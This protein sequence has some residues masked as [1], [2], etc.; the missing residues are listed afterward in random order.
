MRFVTELPQ[1]ILVESG[2]LFDDVRVKEVD[3]R[4]H[5]DFVIARVLERGTLCSVRALVRAVDEERIRTFFR[6]G[7]AFQVSRRTAALW[8]AY[9]D[10]SEEE[11]TPRSSPR[12]RSPY[13]TD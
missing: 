11:C 8:L 7:G 9:L 4:L 1:E 12:I 6:Q 13:W 5:G 10:L 3:F 2:A